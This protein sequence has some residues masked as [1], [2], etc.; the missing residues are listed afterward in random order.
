MRIYTGYELRESKGA[1]VL[2]YGQTGV[3]KS[4][5]TLLTAPAPIFLLQTENRNL[6][7]TFECI[8]EFRPELLKNK[9]LEVGLYES[10]TDTMEFLN[11]GEKQLKR[12]RT[13]V[14][15][16]LTDL[17][18]VKLSREIQDEAYEARKEEEKKVKQ[19]I[20]QS[21]LTLEGYGGIAAQTLRF[22]DTI[23][24]YTREGKYV[25]FTARLDENP[26]WARHYNFA[27]LIKGKE[28]G[29]DFEG[30]FDLIGFVQ[31]NIQEIDGENKI[32][33]PPGIS[34]ASPDRSFMAKWTGSGEKR[35]F[36][37]RWYRIFGTTLDPEE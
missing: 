3:G 17:M 4:L 14:G 20:G 6:D 7:R 27:P 34:F 31:P 8:E 36:I 28:Y 24:R 23:A 1:F 11:T 16:S 9:W 19:L 26:S 25:I 13:I 21:K 10:F 15:D 18:S 33:Y 29:K 5:T 35:D 32:V 30:M 37:M 12:F 2:A 22:T